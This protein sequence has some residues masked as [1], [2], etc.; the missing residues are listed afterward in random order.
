MSLI[1]SLPDQFLEKLWRASMCFV[2]CGSTGIVIIRG[3]TVEN[4]TPQTVFAR[5]GLPHINCA[6]GFAFFFLSCWRTIDDINS[7]AVLPV[8][9]NGHNN[10]NFLRR[11]SILF[12]FSPPDLWSETRVAA[13]LDLFVRRRLL[14]LPLPPRPYRAGTRRRIFAHVWL[15]SLPF[16][17]LL[18]LH[19][20]AVCVRPCAIRWNAVR[21]R[22]AGGSRQRSSLS[23]ASAA[24]TAAD[25]TAA[26]A[27]LATAE[28]RKASR[29]G[30]GM[31]PANGPTTNGAHWSA[32]KRSAP[33]SH[34]RRRWRCCRRPTAD[35][36]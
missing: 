31:L 6:G 27:G 2:R 33:L 7:M 32:A 19:F 10:A 24:A 11:L 30:S 1:F 17:F 12:F 35:E 8:I 25:G 29:L 13:V 3:R 22:S 4:R 5:R 28:P 23:A 26:S 21:P 20:S 36:E 9:V 34:G 16:L 15:A 18:P 14:P